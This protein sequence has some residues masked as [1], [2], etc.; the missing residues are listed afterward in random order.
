MWERLDVPNRDTDTLLNQMQDHL[1][2]NPRTASS[3]DRNLPAPH[4]VVFIRSPLPA[5]QRPLVESI[6]DS[7]PYRRDV[8][9]VQRL[10]QALNR[11][12][13]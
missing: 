5:I 6:V 2:S 7:Y 3:H 12:L 11:R 10:D 4:P 9:V 8:E 13:R 1:L